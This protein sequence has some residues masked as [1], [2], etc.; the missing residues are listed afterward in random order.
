MTADRFITTVEA[1]EMLRRTYRSDGEINLEMVIRRA[2]SDPIRPVSER[3]QM[4][5]S[6][7]VIVGSM[8]LFLIVAGFV[9]FSFG[10]RR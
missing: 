7:L 6:M 4:R 9:Y 1:T 8:M 5:P 3:G 2:A 10:A